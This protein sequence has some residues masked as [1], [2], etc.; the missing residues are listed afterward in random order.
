MSWHACLGGAGTC[1]PAGH[2][3]TPGWTTQRLNVVILQLDAVSREPVQCRRLDF[4]PVISHVP[5]ALVV[6]HNENDVRLRAGLVH[7]V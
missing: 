6:H 2:E 5:E 1:S 7:F 4:G 3:L